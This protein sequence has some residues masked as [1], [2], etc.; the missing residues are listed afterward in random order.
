ML[1]FEF[2]DQRRKGDVFS[3]IIA[4][5]DSKSVIELAQ[6]AIRKSKK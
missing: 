3:M 4:K 2:G 1:G 6:K 5:V